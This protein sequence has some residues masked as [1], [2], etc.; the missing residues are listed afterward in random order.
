MPP[1]SPCFLS[2]RHWPYSLCPPFRLSNSCFQP[3]NSWFPSLRK[4]RVKRLFSKQKS[5]SFWWYQRTISWMPYKKSSNG[6]KILLNFQELATSLVDLP[7][8]VES[9]KKINKLNIANNDF[10][11]IF[12]LKL[13][14]WFL[15]CSIYLTIK[16]YILGWGFWRL[17]GK[18][19]CY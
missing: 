8:G 10:L 13:E 19:W 12:Q 17:S 5:S 7:S 14:N 3:P 9:W 4:W 16:E 18:F 15:I 1:P 11:G 6:S 2:S